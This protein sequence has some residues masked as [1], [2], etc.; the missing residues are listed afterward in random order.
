MIVTLSQ[1]KGSK[2][3]GSVGG[4][5]ALKFVRPIDMQTIG[6]L[7][8]PDCSLPTA[9]KTMCMDFSCQCFAACP[10]WASCWLL[11]LH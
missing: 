2:H 3:I 6:G 4:Y 5:W 1:L 7:E 11:E 9:Q 10:Y 8:N